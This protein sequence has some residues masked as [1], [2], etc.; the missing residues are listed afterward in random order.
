MKAIGVA[1]MMLLRKIFPET[2]GIIVDLFVWLLATCVEV[3]IISLVVASIAKFG[4]NKEFSDFFK[5]S[6]VVV[7][8]IEILIAIIEILMT[9]EGYI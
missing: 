9:I 8:I 5:G 2:M 4:F 7:G 6:F 1:V 3:T